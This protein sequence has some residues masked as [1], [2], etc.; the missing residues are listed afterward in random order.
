MSRKFEA[1]SAFTVL[2]RKIYP[3]S[4]RPDMDWH[5]AY[6]EIAQS[7]EATENCLHGFLSSYGPVLQDEERDLLSRALAYASDGK[8]HDVEDPQTIQSAELLWKSIED[9]DRR[10]IKR[11][12]DQSSL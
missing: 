8:F 4:T 7:F 2:V 3:R 12:R 6:T 1:A 5:D 9:L 11:V 10:L